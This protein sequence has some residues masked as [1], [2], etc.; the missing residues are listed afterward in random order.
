MR[1]AVASLGTV[2]LACGGSTS[3]PETGTADASAVE[4]ATG[5]GD[6]GATT[7]DG[8]DPCSP[9]GVRVCGAG[10]GKAAGCANCTPLLT[11]SGPAAQYGV[12]WSD[13]GD[14]GNTPCALCDDGQG[15]VQRS[16]D[17]F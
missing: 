9:G 3:S 11:G 16:P 4:A 12:C 10:C 7:Y 2:L 13:L 6:A 5:W 17:R 14:L 1:L 8:A 15:C